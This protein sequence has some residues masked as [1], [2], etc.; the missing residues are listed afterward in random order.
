M[1]RPA[2]PNPALARPDFT[3][4]DQDFGMELRDYFAG[5]ALAG[6]MSAPD[7]G[8]WTSPGACEHAAKV[9]Y[10]TADAMLAAR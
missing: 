2:F 5:Q 1:T 7:R 8:V 10:I 4:F 9:A 6:L 3:S